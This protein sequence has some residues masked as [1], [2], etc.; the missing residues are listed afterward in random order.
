[1]IGLCRAVAALASDVPSTSEFDRTLR[2]EL[3]SVAEILGTFTFE[4]AQLVDR[5]ITHET[6]F[7]EQAVLFLQELQCKIQVPPALQLSRIEIPLLRSLY[8]GS[9]AAKTLG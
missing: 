1:V 7:T 6:A 5:T 2:R 4:G 8:S 9:G 3:K